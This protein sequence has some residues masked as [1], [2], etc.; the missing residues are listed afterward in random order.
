MRSTLPKSFNIHPIM[1]WICFD[2]D[3]HLFCN[4]EA[5]KVA[6][7]N[8]Q[9]HRLIICQCEINV[10]PPKNQNS[11]NN[12]SEMTYCHC[13]FQTLNL[14]FRACQKEGFVLFCYP[15]GSRIVY[16]CL[17]EKV[18]SCLISHLTFHLRL[19]GIVLQKLKLHYTA[20][21][22]YMY[23]ITLHVNSS[24]IALHRMYTFRV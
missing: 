13:L 11:S 17:L 24:C 16:C 1:T 21:L 15:I 14:N 10:V 22:R 7:P 20:C 6:A 4:H 9:V 3:L 23:S 5:G 12:L 18:R 8:N 19:H 2:N